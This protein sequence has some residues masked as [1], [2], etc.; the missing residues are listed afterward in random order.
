MIRGADER[1]WNQHQ[2]IVEA[3]LRRDQIIEKMRHEKHPNGDD[4]N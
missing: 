4:R 3:E 2:E 1:F